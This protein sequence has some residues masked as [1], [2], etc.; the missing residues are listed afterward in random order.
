MYHTNSGHRLRAMY[1]GPDGIV[2]N[3]GLRYNTVPAG[4]AYDMPRLLDG[5]RRELPDKRAEGVIAIRGVKP[6]DIPAEMWDA[7]TDQGWTVGTRG[8]WVSCWAGHTRVHV[9]FL[10]DMLQAK[11]PL[12]DVHQDGG[13]IALL[14]GQYHEL[15]GAP[16]HAT[17]GVSAH[18]AIR[19]LCRPM[20]RR[21]D[22]AKPTA[23]RWLADDTA[24]ELRGV[25][26]LVW[27]LDP[28]LRS[29]A[30]GPDV[31]EHTFDVNAQYLAAARNAIIA[32]DQLKR[33]GG[34][35]EFDRGRAGYWLIDAPA[36]GFVYPPVVRGKGQVWVTTPVMEY[37]YQRPELGAPPRIIDS[38][39]APGRTV[40]R[41]W[42]ERVRQARAELLG[43][44]SGLGGQLLR[45]VK[46]TYTQAIGMLGRP[47][48]RIHRRDWYDTI[49]DLARI[50]LM[51]RIDRVHAATGL[52]PI[53]VSTDA[54]TYRTELPAELL[55]LHLGIGSGIGQ[56]KHVSTR[57]AA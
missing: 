9:G 16:F 6:G 39:T 23:P 52:V 42:A 2:Y 7:V 47:G 20:P 28:M 48:G 33:T 56:F 27:K 18:G 46:S 12:F 44:D 54:V 34:G 22:A 8:S 41:P 35:Q 57:A 17:A 38:Y 36:A 1:I 4:L 19:E 50:N 51:R 5:F 14:L 13:E 31:V 26:P 30:G 10:D 3:N 43:E 25:G 40:L 11:T 53:E 21:A 55:G 32:P 45:A 49:V 15:T 24:K 37:L 29:A